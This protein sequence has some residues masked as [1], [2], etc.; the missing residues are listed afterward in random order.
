MLCV[1]ATCA[2]F[3]AS[4]FVDAD[5]PTRNAPLSG[6]MFFFSDKVIVL[7]DKNVPRHFSS[8]VYPT[9]RTTPFL[10]EANNAPHPISMFGILS[11]K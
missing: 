2:T 6:G 7:S 1:L 5:F 4:E 11:P 10:G 3:V 9:P 8:W